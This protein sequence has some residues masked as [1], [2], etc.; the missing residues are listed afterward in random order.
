M[1]I[2]HT[3]KYQFI[4]R[5]IAACLFF[6][7][8]AASPIYSQEIRFNNLSVNEGLSHYTVTA[9]CQD[10]Q[11]F[12]WI[13]TADGLNRFDGNRFVVYK[14]VP[15]DTTSISGNSILSI[16]EDGEGYLWIGVEN[17]GLNRFNPRSEIFTRFYSVPDNPNSLSHNDVTGITG[18][19]IGNIWLGTRKGLSVLP[20]GEKNKPDPSF[21]NFYKGENP[22][23]TITD[24]IIYSIFHDSKGNLW[25][26]LSNG[27]GTDKLELKYDNGISF[28]RTN[29][30]NNPTNPN[31][32]SGRWALYTFEDSK[33]RIWFSY[34]NEGLTKYEPSK[35][36]FTRYILDPSFERSLPDNNIEMVIEDDNKN[37]WAATY[38]GGLAKLVEDPLSGRE[39]FEKFQFDVKDQLSI[40]DNRLTTLFK[41]RSGII[42]I[43][44]AGHGL[45]RF[46]PKSQ[47]T[48]INLTDASGK[49]RYTPSC[50]HRTKEG[51]LWAGTYEGILFRISKDGSRTDR[52]KLNYEGK[53]V[54]QNPL[55]TSFCEDEEGTFWITTTR[56]GIYYILKG[57]LA[58]QTPQFNRV[59]APASD[60]PI[61]YPF[62][63]LSVKEN[64]RGELIFGTY[65]ENSIQVLS[66]EN[67]LKKNFL[68][69]FYNLKAFTWSIENDGEYNWLG[70]YAN[71]LTKVDF[72]SGKSISGFKP[73]P[74][75]LYNSRGIP[76]ADVYSIYKASDGSIWF[77]T[78]KSLSKLNPG[79]DTLKHYRFRDG[80]SS[81]SVYGILEDKEGNIW[82]S[83]YNGIS[84]IE[85]KTGTFTNYYRE[86]GLQANE[87]NQYSYHKDR[88]GVL[89]FGSVLGITVIKPQAAGNKERFPVMKITGIH[90]SNLPV[91]DKALIEKGIIEESISFADEIILPNDKNDFTIEFSA[92]DYSSSSKIKYRYFL[93]GYSGEWTTLSKGS[94]VNF[95]NLE[96]KTYIFKVKSTNNEGIWNEDYARI[97]VTILPP[98]WNTWWF[99]LLGLLI[100]G[101]IIYAIYSYRIKAAEKKQIE[102][103]KLVEEQTLELKERNADLE[104]FSYSV[105]HDLRAPL[106]SIY[107]FSQIINEDFG[108][109]LPDEARNYFEK[110]T[111][112]AKN[113][114]EL[115][116]GILKL[117]RVSRIEMNRA[118]INLSVIA[119]SIIEELRVV[120]LDKPLKVRIQPDIM[121]KGDNTLL[122]TVIENLLSN[123]AKF[124]SG[125]EEIIIEMGKTRAFDKSK[126]NAAEVIFI[127]DNGVGFDMKYS[128]K[129]F[130]VFHRLHSASEF[131]GT[132]IG[133]ANV[134]KIITRHGG[135]IWAESEQNNGTTFYFNIPQA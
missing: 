109:Q 2:R 127:K 11:G 53:P 5:L 72:R 102:L 73:I 17:G 24:N 23:S 54:R 108:H 66:R 71:G 84:K 50:I 135:V 40:P 28:K 113:M 6:L 46:N 36:K 130:Q 125:K 87:F 39:Y 4:S 57:D 96:P 14:N 55:I 21:I 44:T 99:K 112:A 90:L 27:F 75:D 15:A 89:Y 79:T 8:A 31:S 20:A 56:G 82:V 30:I 122:T 12:I 35:R 32:P 19:K 59:P 41:D 106:R 116:D 83:T 86:D 74:K 25:L 47:F 29:F 101:A 9:F 13:G 121:V 61:K 111:K 10:R 78:L 85:P 124:S 94:S 69:R 98:F 1:N 104:A 114:T 7:A 81:E 129:L 37:I 120:Y 3:A 118:P 93:E 64:S 65:N 115:I 133:L 77:G 38:G 62:G 42:W 128:E 126:T 117:A 68:F 52:F 70:S 43:G 91:E 119:E 67:K 48:H 131:S 110:I 97:K 95:M 34:W 88:E 18:D 100:S 51:N 60:E 49:I 45:S 123:A 105:S 76:W 134:K 103:Q 58:S 63:Y 92:L 107:S 33:G 132:G 16:Y 22:E 26:S 80:L